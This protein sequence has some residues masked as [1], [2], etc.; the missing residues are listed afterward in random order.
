MCTNDNCEKKYFSVP[1]GAVRLSQWFVNKVQGIALRSVMGING[2]YK[3][4]E[5]F[6]DS[7][8]II[9]VT[10]VTI[11]RWLQRLGTYCH[12]INKKLSM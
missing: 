3:K 1:P 12:N 5:K 11:F 8:K 2:V 7:A 4:A 6:L 9:K 10:A